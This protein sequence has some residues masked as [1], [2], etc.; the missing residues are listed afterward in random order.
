M[1][2][3]LRSVEI[4]NALLENERATRA[5]STAMHRMFVNLEANTKETFRNTERVRA[6]E[7]EAAQL[8][9]AVE[10]L[11]HLEQERVDL[12][13]E[14]LRLEREKLDVQ[15]AQDEISGSYEITKLEHDTKRVELET[16]SR[17]AQIEAA[18]DAARG[19]ATFLQTRAGWGVLVLCGMMIAWLM[20]TAQFSDLVSNLVALSKGWR[21]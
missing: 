8:R 16:K 5:A 4:A 15:Q 9:A 7:R 14:E 3:G 18:R 20:G 21:S 11:V 2:D 1:A 19:F 13:K 17:E 10:T 6:L 12:R